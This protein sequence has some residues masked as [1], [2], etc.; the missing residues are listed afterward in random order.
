MVKR[1]NAG[2]DLKLTLPVVWFR[3]RKK[4]SLFMFTNTELAKS[5]SF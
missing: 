5:A 3:K 1:E 2:N 4:S